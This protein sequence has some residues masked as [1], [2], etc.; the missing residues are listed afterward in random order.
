M[1]TRLRAKFRA[2]GSLM[3]YQQIN[4]STSSTDDELSDIM[5]PSP[6][7]EADPLEPEASHPSD[8]SISPKKYLP[9][10]FS[11]HAQPRSPSPQLTAATENEPSLLGTSAPLLTNH[12]LTYFL[13]NC[14]IW[15][16]AT[17]S[18]PASTDDD[19]ESPSL[20]PST[21][22]AQPGAGT[23]PSFK[24]GRGDHLNSEKSDW[25]SQRREQGKRRQ[26]KQLNLRPQ[27]LLDINYGKSGSRAINVELAYYE[28][29]CVCW[30]QTKSAGYPLKPGES[31]RRM[32]EQGAWSTDSLSEQKKNVFGCRTNE[33]SPSRH[34]STEVAITRGSES[35][36]SQI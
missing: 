10:F 34:N 11:D 8:H 19:S 6:H 4:Y 17:A 15:A 7:I 22:S 23:A 16:T 28:I 18:R 20:A 9:Q 27:R 14:P 30:L 12:S 36:M 35:S 32:K 26:R 31:L 5:I 25:F 3:H 29:A 2:G 24:R 21:T 13:S 33:R 1:D